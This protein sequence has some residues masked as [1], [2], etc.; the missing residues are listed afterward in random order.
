LSDDRQAEEVGGRTQKPDPHL[1]RRRAFRLLAAGLL[2]AVAVAVGLRFGLQTPQGRAL[3]LSHLEGLS[4]G[5]AGRL[6]IEGVEGDVWR[7]FTVRRLQVID[8]KGAWLDARNVEV[9]W[10]PIALLRLRVH[11]LGLTFESL[12]LSRRPAMG[13][14]GQGGGRSPVSLVFDDIHGRIETQPAFSGAPGRFQVKLNLDLE[15]SG[16]V[17]GA[18]ALD[19]LLHA[20][21][22]LKAKFQLGSSKHMLLEA[23][24]QEAGGGALAGALGLPTGQRFKLD[25]MAI[26]D[27]KGGKLHLL[28]LTGARPIARADAAWSKAGG[29][30]TAALSLDASSLTAPYLHALGPEL[31]LV[32]GG[33]G[34]GHDRY[35]FALQAS[36]E[37]AALSASGTLD[38]HRMASVGDWRVRAAVADA[39]RI[40]A[41]P[42]MGAVALDGALSGSLADWSF[43]GRADA[44]K[45]DYGGYTLARLSGP[46]SLS[47]SKHELR[48][49]MTLDG[50]GGAGEGTWAVAAGP[51]PKL[52]A[53]I[54]RLADGR[55]LARSLKAQGDG[56]DLDAVGEKGLFGDLAF[57]GDLKLT[58][59]AAIRPGAQGGVEARWSAGQRKAGEPWVFTLDAEGAGFASGAPAL[60]RLLGPKPKLNAQASWRDDVLTLSQSELKGSASDVQ[61]TG[62]VGSKTGLDLKLK[63]S[64]QGPLTFG[65]LTIGGAG[66]GVST[67][68]GPFGATKSDM[69]ADFQRVDV[70]KLSLRGMHVV[71]TIASSAAG[72]DGQIGLTATGDGGPAH[73]KAV[74]HFAGDDIVLNN[75][76]VAAG[77]AKAAGAVSLRKLSPIGADLRFSVDQGVFIAG[78]HAEGHVAITGSPDNP[79][80]DA[81]VSMNNLVLANSSK[82]PSPLHV[83]QAKITAHGPLAQLPYTIAG[84]ATTNGVPVRLNGGGIAGM[85]KAYALS[86]QGAGRV[87]TTDFRTRTPLQLRWEDGDLA[88]KGGVAVSSGGG[89]DVDAERSGQDL[90]A[91]LSMVA[92][93][94]GTLNAD[95]AGQISGVL[96]LKGHGEA[97]D[98]DL[99]AHLDG[100][101]SRDAPAKLGLAGDVHAV[102]SGGKLTV[103]ASASGAQTNGKADVDL[104]LPV[105]ASAQPFQF[106]LDRAAPITGRVDVDAEMQPIWD[107]FFG[108]DRELGGRLTAQGALTGSLAAPKFTGQAAIANGRFE[109]AGTG[110]KLRN[111]AA[112]IAVRDDA[113]E[114]SKFTANDS[115]GGTVSGDGTMS[116]IRSGSST[117]TLKAVNFRLLD[118]E[119]AKATT[120]GDVTVVRDADGKARLTGTLTVDRADISTVS[121]RRPAGVVTLD[122]IEKNRPIDEGEAAQP[123]PAGGGAVALDVSIR[124]PGRVFVKGRGLNAEMS[125][126]AHVGGT[127]A[128]PVLEGV[129]RVVRGDYDLAG[130]RFTIDDNGTVRLATSPDQMRLDLT[131]TLEQ[132]TITA[133]V[134]IKGTAAK[135]EITLTSTPVLPS[136][137]V[138]SQVLF[139]QS[140]AQLQ[141]VQ[142]AQL[143]ATVASL[144]TGGGVDVMGGLANFAKLDR[145]AL[146]AGDTTNAN[147][148]AVNG[149]VTVSGGKYIGN[150]V[151]LEVTGGG[152]QGPSAQVEV[153]ASRAF[154]IVSQVGGDVGAKLSV[155]WRMDYGR[156]KKPKKKAVK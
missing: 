122:V 7:D 139:G 137:E 90:H 74:Y 12:D 141:P 1:R 154:S 105:Q 150:K 3:V 143:A 55:L 129:A 16:A 2:A 96:S 152:R 37:N 40:L 77:G 14:G 56:L 106:N 97:L 101:R 140:A 44:Q 13:G 22:G 51:R 73:A 116:L 108:G 124:A 17:S 48:L 128:A 21:D 94:L 113:V 131:A 115:A 57:R 27:G 23:Q 29:A 78:G 11:V 86:F 156:P 125:L 50:A 146:G 9:R 83:G 62:A 75:L 118:N 84:D 148:T 123:A 59:L 135:P 102:L 117:L 82:G 85:G 28:A 138:L 33:R 120:S 81:S 89:L 130:K 72:L 92:L 76:D 100:A 36:A 114:V 25:A 104:A 61:V 39:S 98:G 26:G 43:T 18:V 6:H 66:S 10:R 69:T 107:L 136:D 5:S 53:D 47:S 54:S 95:L 67:V 132:Q 20:G 145:I 127:T 79:L 155:R 112:Q 99:N 42:K 71:A 93:D 35:A 134:K 32:G 46:I 8:A 41:S 63:W 133:V 119:T 142:A 87:R 68:Q 52:S 153:T 15:R 49:Q 34:T 144:A 147:G 45:F 109:D 58:R 80:A 151:Y 91:K 88:V 70:P 38:A 19:S 64:V 103:D 126:N 110:L 31:S 24:A 149:G 121:S 60:D 4:L 111:L 30:G 65:A